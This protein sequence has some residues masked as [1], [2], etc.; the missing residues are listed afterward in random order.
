MQAFQR[1]NINFVSNYN[2]IFIDAAFCGGE[3]EEGTR[4]FNIFEQR[5]SIASLPWQRFGKNACS[6][7]TAEVYTYNSRT[8]YCIT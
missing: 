8:K 5:D 6:R 4:L 3:K 2:F 1:N 7:F